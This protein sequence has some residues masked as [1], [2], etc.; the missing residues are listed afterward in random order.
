MLQAVRLRLGHHSRRC[1]GW[2]VSDGYLQTQ[3]PNNPTTM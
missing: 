2:Y 1:T 3:E